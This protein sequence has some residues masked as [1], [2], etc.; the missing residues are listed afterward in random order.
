MI[1]CASTN[2][3]FDQAAILTNKLAILTMYLHEQY[4]LYSDKVNNL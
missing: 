2:T 4:K 1:N 3:L